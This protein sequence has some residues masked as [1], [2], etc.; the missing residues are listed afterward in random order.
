MRQRPYDCLTPI[1]AH[2]H[3]EA[4]VRLAPHDRL[5]AIMGAVIMRTGEGRCGVGAG[6]AKA[7]TLSLAPG[8]GSI[9]SPC[10]AG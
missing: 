7:A 3:R 8:P 10:R 9:G 2:D 4:L 5:T 1:T 6:S